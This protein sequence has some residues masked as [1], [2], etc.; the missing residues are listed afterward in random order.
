MAYF[1]LAAKKQR[2]ARLHK[3]RASVGRLRRALLERLEDRYLLASIPFGALPDDTAE[4]MLGDVLVTVVLLESDSSISPFDASTEDWTPDLI[5]GV[6][7]K[8]AEGLNWWTQTLDAMENVRD[9]LLTFTIDWTYADNPARIGYEPISR[10]STDFPLW[11]QDFLSSVGFSQG[12]DFLA[13]IRAFNNAQRIAHE[14]HW[15]FTIFIVN[16]A[17]ELAAGSGVM[18]PDSSQDGRFLGTGPGGSYLPGQL[19][20]SFAYAGGHAI[21]VPADRPASS[22]AHETGHIFWAFDEYN[23]TTTSYSLTRGYYNTQNTNANPSPSYTPEDSIMSSGASLTAAYAGFTT[24]TSSQETIGW[25]DSDG[26]GIFD[27]LDVNFSLEGSGQYDSGAGTFRF[28][29]KSAV[30][31]L[32]NQNPSGLQND[33]TINEIRRAEVKFDDGEW[34]TIG[35]YKAYQVNLDLEFSVPGNPSTITLRTHD[36]R[37]GV[38]SDE[39]VY[40][41]SGPPGQHTPGPGAGGYV[42]SDPDSDGW[43]DP[44]EWGMGGWQVGL[45]DQLG[46]KL[47]LRQ[48]AQPDNFVHLIELNLFNTGAILT[49]VGGDVSSAIIRA[50]DS[51]SAPAAGRVFGVASSVGGGVYGDTFTSGRRLMAEFLSPVT[52]VS[53]KAY[54]VEAGSVARMEAFNA[55]GEVIARVTTGV[56]SHNASREL[57]IERG[58]ADIAYVVVKGHAGTKVV[59]DDLAWGA[60][61]STTTD[62]LGAWTLPTL[63]PG[64][65]RVA[66][67]PKPRYV[68]TGPETGYLEIVVDAGGIRGQN[69]HFYHLP[70]PWH[71]ESQP[72]DVNANGKVTAQD[73]LHIVNWL[74]GRVGQGS[75][76]PPEPE[77]G[78]FFLD[79]SDDGR[80]TAFDA[81]LVVN[82][83]NRLASLA[84]VSASTSTQT[85]GFSSES[86][87]AEGEAASLSG[88]SGMDLAAR[89][90]STSPLHAES[91][92]GVDPTSGGC[93]CGQCDAITAVALSRVAESAA[94]TGDDELEQQRSNS[95]QTHLDIE[96][97]AALADDLATSSQRKRRG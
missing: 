74:N 91:I 47:N 12:S 4:F 65:Y 26:D 84:P 96:L 29:G 15:A 17:A 86:I 13:N 32:Q 41:V 85:T 71:N 60:V 63:P 30:R 80:C 6:K 56:L 69:F 3:Q 21:T 93:T 66:V 19:P 76:L 39:Y 50:I 55:G 7:S 81:L 87:A 77:P 58:A 1:P 59:L 24:S 57:K 5:S 62:A 64:E 43:Q 28:L 78:D 22:V 53:I 49:A 51:T 48:T 44:G 88:L 31:T 46:N 40:T 94:K 16:N 68:Q 52:S 25:K 18:F 38:S 23:R 45:V 33:I 92:P 82:E 83:L 79:V 67:T 8:V 61:S 11:S 72:L 90:Y 20:L 54:G 36:T 73:A 14:T 89:Y 97:L 10:P 70:N 9:G 34:Q 35:T 2:P 27:V 37:T 95:N 42:I 75:E